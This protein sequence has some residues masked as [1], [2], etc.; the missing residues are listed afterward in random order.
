[1]WNDQRQ[2]AHVGF[3]M[4]EGTCLRLRG[5]LIKEQAHP[6]GTQEKHHQPSFLTPA[7]RRKANES[8]KNLKVATARVSSFSVDSGVHYH[9]DVRPVE[10]FQSKEGKEHP[11]SRPGRSGGLRARSLQNLGHAKV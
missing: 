5:A 2:A 7:C 3:L 1:V 8:C 11:S 9:L 6:T 4:G 10:K